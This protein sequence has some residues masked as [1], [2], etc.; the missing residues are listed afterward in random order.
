MVFSDSAINAD[1]ERD[2]RTG[3]PEVILAEGKTPE[4]VLELTRGFLDRRG[5]AIVSRVRPRVLQLLEREAGADQIDRYSLARMAVLRRDD[6]AVVSTGGNVG[7]VTAG[8]SDLGVAQEAQVIAQE[9][10]C[11]TRLVADVG[12]AGL[13]RLVNPLEGLLAWG[14]D[15]VIVVAGMDGALPSVVAGLVD[16]PV[17]GLPTS[18]GY[19]MGSGGLAAILSMLQSCVPGLAVVNVDNGIGAGASAARIA[20]RVA[21]ARGAR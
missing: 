19:G 9:M 13:H 18:K 7:I 17:I 2:L 11:A 10:G 14:A 12:V 8:A 20:N 21:A 16:V 15:A 3:V 1:F 6:T 4:V 5:R